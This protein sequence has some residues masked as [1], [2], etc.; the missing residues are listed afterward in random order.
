MAGKL[1]GKAGQPAA[2]ATKIKPFHNTVGC[3][4]EGRGVAGAGACHKG[5]FHG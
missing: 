3:S 1:L 2:T 5:L 4:R